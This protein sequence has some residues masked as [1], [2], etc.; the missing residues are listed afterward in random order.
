MEKSIIFNAEMI[1]AILQNRKVQT[2]KII[3][4][5]NGQ[6]PDTFKRNKFYKLVD[7]LN[8]KNGLFAGFYSNTDVFTFEE[9]KHVNAIYFK[10]PYQVGDIL[11][12]KET[13]GITNPF[14]DFSKN[15]VTAEY[16]F[17][18]GFSKGKR[19]PITREM[20][21]N[22]GAW[23]SSICMPKVAARIF[24]KV[25]DIRVERIRGITAGDCKREGVN[26]DFPIADIFSADEYIDEYKKNWNSKYKNW[27]ENP[28][29]W[30]IEFKLMNHKNFIKELEEKYTDCKFFIRNKEEQLELL[31]NNKAY[32]NDDNFLDNIIDI[33]KDYLTEDELWN[34]VT[35]YDIDNEIPPTR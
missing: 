6:T 22:L 32:L 29:V 17:K 31:Y 16:M 35:T 18:A 2:R 10:C 12:V 1:N 23:K 3:K 24:L 13:W 27:D 11:W 26:L 8:N 19:I 7:K 28:W 34:I 33:G 14:G 25:V 30:V 21:K 15:N 9:E 20:E 4:Y 5:S